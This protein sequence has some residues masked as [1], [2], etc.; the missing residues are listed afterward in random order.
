MTDQRP[1]TDGRSHDASAVEWDQARR[2]A[3]AAGGAAPLPPLKAGLY[4]A[5]CD[6]RVLAEDVVALSDLPAFASSSVDGYAVRGAGPWQVVRTVLPG[7]VSEPIGRDGAAVRIATGAMVPADTEAIVR[8]EE[9]E[10]L[11]E[12][13]IDGRPRARREWRVQGEQARRGTLLIPAGTVI[14]PAVLGVAAS[15][16]YDRLLVRPRPRLTLVLL[17]DEVATAG[18]SGDG[19]LR[20]A[21]GPQLPAWARRLGF[22][23]PAVIGPV[24]DDADALRDALRQA[25]GSGADL[26]A[27]AGGTMFGPTDF[28]RPTL[29]ESG[30]EY[31][32]E[33]VRSRPGRPMLLA[34]LG[35]GTRGREGGETPTVLV[36]GMPGRPQPALLTLLTLA[37]PAAA[38]MTGRPLPP[39]SGVVLGAP[40]P[41]R[42]GQTRLA[43]VRLDAEGRAFP[44]ERDRFEAEGAPSSDAPS[45][46]DMAGAAGFAVIA[47]GADAAAGDRVPLLALPLTPGEQRVLIS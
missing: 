43:L 9:T 32:V 31:L 23:V 4:D 25:V 26:V 40:I 33:S 16:G 46:A 38:G 11:P 47:P 30:A 12:G 21:I 17:G 19:R 20:D 39:L 27:T 35:G 3:H 10:T 14:T 44:T 24:P 28:L 15:A 1:G 29:A 22:D 42:R 41:G 6:G 7:S 37:V 34:R 8:V 2:L 45:A 36:A 13:R 5:D 18:P